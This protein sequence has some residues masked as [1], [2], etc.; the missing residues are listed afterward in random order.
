VEIQRGVQLGA[1]HQTLGIAAESR[2]YVQLTPTG[3]VIWDLGTGTK[4]KVD[5]TVVTKESFA[6]PPRV[7]AILGADT[8]DLKRQWEESEGFDD[9]RETIFAELTARGVDLRPGTRQVSTR[10]TRPQENTPE[11]K[12]YMRQV[13]PMMVE[14][15]KSKVAQEQLAMQGKIIDWDAINAD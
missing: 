6:V 4:H 10:A 13:F 7:K 12:A 14:L 2:V 15:M 11:A 1:L 5:G 9:D 8:D 3:V